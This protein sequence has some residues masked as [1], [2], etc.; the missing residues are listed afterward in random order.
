MSRK[1]RS[2]GRK[3]SDM[4]RCVQFPACVAVALFF[5]AGA[6]GCTG[7]IPGSG[8]SPERATNQPDPTQGTSTGGAGGEMAP[9]ANPAGPPGTRPL[10]R[11]SRDELANTV[12]DLLGASTPLPATLTDMVSPSGFQQSGNISKVEA[13]GLIDWTG[14]VAAA[15]VEKVLP[16]SGCSATGATR[17]A[18][19]AC[20]RTFIAAFGRRAFRRPLSQ[21]E[22]DELF[23]YYADKLRTALAYD[24]RTAISG[25]VWLMLQSP[26]FLYHW[27]RSAEP[28]QAVNGRIALGPHEIAA[29]LSYLFWSSMPDDALL[30]A[31]DAGNLSNTEQ[32]DA[33]ARRLLADDKGAR[34]A[35]NFIL[36]WVGIID[37][38]Q[39]TKADKYAFTAPLGAAMVAE[40]KRSVRAVFANDGSLDR[41]FTSS[42]TTIDD[43]NLAKIY[44]YTGALGN[45]PVTLDPTQRAGLLTSAAFLTSQTLHSDLNP[46]KR[47]LAVVQRLLCRTIPSAPANVP[48]AKPA[49]PNQSTRKRLTEHD[50]NACAIGCHSAFSPIGMAFEHYDGV[51]AYRTMDGGEPVD[52]SATIQLASGDSVN[53][54]DAVEL[55]RVLAQS[56]E[57]RACVA[58]QWLRFVLQR[59]DTDA[60][61]PSLAVTQGITM[62]KDPDLRVLM[63]AITTTP[64]FISRSP[65]PGE[66]ISAEVQP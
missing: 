26:R 29:R 64:A 45:T 22:Q 48:P 53:V 40:S 23:T 21:I 35:E 8:T 28:A 15:G 61:Q 2:S 6:A 60:D 30:D 55:S 10:R 5:S 62:G 1:A 51:G 59:S 9:A 47:G 34:V 20:A 54:A 57:V 43:P 4:T 3:E 49:D 24:H 56:E 32:I 38:S 36:Q 7:H 58:R 46:I 27:E 42:A 50:Q 18:E 16:L 37:V 13:E 66:T 44:G 12:S 33:Q 31:A 39:M 19:D 17:T 11:L 52:S 65:S 25:L 63:A 14:A 41:L